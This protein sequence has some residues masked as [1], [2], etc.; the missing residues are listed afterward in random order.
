[1]VSKIDHIGI[2]VKDLENSLKKYTGL[3]G[4]GSRKD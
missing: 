3:L 1:M 4:L 2:F